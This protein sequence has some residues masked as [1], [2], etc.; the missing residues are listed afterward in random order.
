LVGGGSTAAFVTI[1]KRSGRL[2][3]WVALCRAGSVRFSGSAGFGS[4]LLGVSDRG[5][6]PQVV[7]DEVAAYLRCGLLQH[8]FARFS[9]KTC[10]KDRLV[11][12]SCKNRR[13]CPSCIAK[14]SALTAA[15]LVDTVLP[16]C[17]YRQWTLCLPYELRFRLI[18]DGALFTKV[19]R[20]FVRT[21]F[22][23]QR[24]QAKAAGYP[25]VHTG[26]VTFAQRFGSLL[27]LN[28]HAHTWIT[29]GVFVEQDDGKLSF[30]SLPAPTDEDVEALCRRLAQRITKVC[31]R[32][33]EE[34]LVDDEDA[35]MASVQAEAVRAPVRRPHFFDDIPEPKARPRAALTAQHAGFSLH[36]GL[37]VEA[38]RRKK[39]ERL[40]RYG[41]RPPFAQKRLSVT[42]SG[43]V[44]LK[45]RKPYY[46]GQTELMLDPTAFLRRLFAIIPPPRW[47]LTRYH[48]IFGACVA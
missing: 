32:D 15:H 44:R 11:A 27:Q 8:G 1:F 43:K 45:L 40:L 25:E 36:A 14:R 4:G 42:P 26:S 34:L 13:L 29:D 38:K 47:H 6:Y 17:P 39:L 21:V 41:S 5:G 2:Q 16:V 24:R 35:L 12:Y 33:D 28:P 23:W 48:G 19:I 22:S 31:A 10:G 20:T 7:K 46:T 9:C 37:W 18:R 3:S 30:V